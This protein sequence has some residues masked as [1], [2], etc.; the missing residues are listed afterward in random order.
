MKTL[1]K[2]RFQGNAQLTGFGFDVMLKLSNVSGLLQYAREVSDP[3]SGEYRQFLTPQQIGQRYGASPASV[4]A[5][6]K[7]FAS[8][9]LK[10]TTWPQNMLMHVAGPQS[11][12]QSAF[13]TTLGI[14]K[15]GTDTVIGPS[16]SPS[17]PANLA[18]AG[19]PNIVMWP[20]RF[21]KPNIKQASPLLNAVLGYAPQQVAAGFDYDGAYAAGYTGKGI[22]IGVIGTGP[23]AV[24]GVDGI[25]LGDVEAARAL[26]GVQGTSTIT[27]PPVGNAAGGAAY[28]AG[29]F[30]TPPTVNSGSGC[31]PNETNPNDGIFGGESPSAGC[32]PEDIETQIDTESA[33]LLA[34][35]STVEYY[36]A[37]NPNDFCNAS[38]FPGAGNSVAPATCAPGTGVPA[39]GLFEADAEIQQAIADNTADVLSLSYA[40]SELDVQQA[41]NTTSTLTYQQFEQS[42]FA[43]LAAEG[44]AVFVSSGDTGANEC[45]GTG[46]TSN[47]N[48]LCA[49]YPSTDPN[50]VAVGGVTIPLTGSGQLEGP[51]AAWGVQTFSGEAGS[52]GGLSILFPTLSYQSG[53]DYYTPAGEVP[54]SSR[55]VPDVSLLGD[56]STG[57]GV[58]YDAD[59]T[60]G[61]YST[62]TSIYGGTS[63]AAPE[64][65][66][67]WSLVLQACAQTTSCASKGSGPHPYRL[68]DPNPLFYAAYGDGTAATYGSTFYNVT[69][70]S[71]QQTCQQ[72]GSSPPTPGPPCPSSSPSLDPG[73]SAGP[74]YNLV[75]GIG[76]PF[77]RALIKTIVGV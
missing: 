37:Y 3:K 36:L 65:A 28:S 51:I 72:P 58:V 67:M 21:L 42:E 73:Y 33:A 69:Y 4:A 14:Y 66:A 49:S 59:P 18:V 48:S 16:K 19:S 10:V 11:A 7:Y 2:A 17:L 44:I 5:T 15:L 68:G 71:N 32:D 70:G 9:G 46:P 76:A 57:I 56:P 60:L 64:M 8:Y 20:S 52:G 22:N 45:Q 31:G 74:G 55:G 13:N 50:V 75:T 62:S 63:V 30:T 38:G 43:A 41:P 25:T 27:L 1:Q 26:F 53:V 6:E 29:G 35:N 23:I 47:E 12:I 34:P 24:S 77:G 61:G 40:E 39:Q 54:L